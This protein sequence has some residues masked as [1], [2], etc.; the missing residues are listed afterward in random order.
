MSSQLPPT[1]IYSEA[2][3]SLWFDAPP[4]EMERATPFCKVPYAV[5]RSVDLQDPD[6]PWVEFRDD[7]A[8]RQGFA[9]RIQRKL[10][11]QRRVILTA[12][13]AGVLHEAIRAGVGIG[14]LPL[15]IA[16][17]DPSLVRWHNPNLEL[18]RALKIY[19]NPDFQDFAR[20]KA[21]T[22]WLERCK[23]IFEAHR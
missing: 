9:Q 12:T 8:L 1:T 2:T 19:I 17:P 22:S 11:T 21:V 18:E 23:P 16:D 3:V 5:Y 14:F 13:D 4:L 7:R 6:P 20:V 10:G 15:C